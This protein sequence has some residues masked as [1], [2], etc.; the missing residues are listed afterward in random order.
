MSTVY[1]LFLG[2]LRGL[3]LVLRRIFTEPPDEPQ[4]SR[5]HLLLWIPKPGFVWLLAA[6]RQTKG[7]LRGPLAKAEALLF[8]ACM[9]G[10]HCLLPSTAQPQGFTTNASLLVLVNLLPVSLPFQVMLIQ[11]WQISPL[12]SEDE[13]F[14]FASEKEKWGFVVLASPTLSS[15]QSLR[16]WSMTKGREIP[17]LWSQL[18]LE[19]KTAN[20]IRT[21]RHKALLET[22]CKQQIS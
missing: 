12:L 7:C 5:A 8:N 19:K 15:I 17:F 20:L 2:G 3:W 21:R 22:M 9:E 1:W 14:E 13:F 18:T 6:R 16:C 11:L 4:E 10:W